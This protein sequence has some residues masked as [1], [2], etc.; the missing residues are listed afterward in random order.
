M[1]LLAVAAITLSLLAS[2]SAQANL[3]R[4]ISAPVQ[5]SQAIRM[6]AKARSQ[7]AAQISASFRRRDS[8]HFQGSRT[9]PRKH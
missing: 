1:K 7:C 5:D 2:T 8:P 4:A 9:T 6:L 3:A